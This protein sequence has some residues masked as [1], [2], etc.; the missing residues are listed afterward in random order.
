MINLS[1]AE[2]S[3]AR[4]KRRFSAGGNRACPVDSS[5]QIIHFCAQLAGRPRTSMA[6]DCAS[7]SA[8]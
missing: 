3:A 7:T 6:V 4:A 8:R 5:A 2:G 1:G